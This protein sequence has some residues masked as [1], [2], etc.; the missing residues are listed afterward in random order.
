MPDN[1]NLEQ[2]FEPPSTIRLQVINAGMPEWPKLLAAERDRLRCLKAGW[3]NLL[4]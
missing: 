2:I 3:R 1:K 4:A